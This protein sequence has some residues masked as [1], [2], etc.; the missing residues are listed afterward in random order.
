EY[1][2][3][4]LCVSSLQ[5]FIISVIYEGRYPRTTL[6]NWNEYP[7]H[8][9]PSNGKNRSLQVLGTDHSG[10]TR[11]YSYAMFNCAETRETRAHVDACFVSFFSIFCAYN[12][13]FMNAPRR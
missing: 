3:S 9:F 4:L 13:N 2:F 5:C 11:Y 12:T 7:W 6:T 10:V 8:C 1:I